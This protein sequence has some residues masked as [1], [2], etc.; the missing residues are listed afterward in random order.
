[1]ELFLL[2][3]P[4][5]SPKTH[6]SGPLVDSRISEHYFKSQTYP[7]SCV[8]SDREPRFLHVKKERPLGIPDRIREA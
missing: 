3:L 8:T 5:P 4:P 2:C 1:M 7:L 6:V